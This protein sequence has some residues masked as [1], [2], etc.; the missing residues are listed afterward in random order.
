MCNGSSMLRRFRFLILSLLL[1]VLLGGCRGISK[2]PVAM[3]LS[4]N[5]EV[6]NDAILRF[7]DSPHFPQL[8]EIC[9][10][11]V[12][13]SRHEIRYDCTRVFDLRPEPKAVPYLIQALKD[14]HW[15]VR[16]GAVRALATSGDDRA[17]E[18][19]LELLKDDE[20][21]I[22]QYAAQAFQ[23]FKHPGAVSP[24]I[25]LLRYDRPPTNNGVRDDTNADVAK[26]LGNQGDKKALGHLAR[27]LEYPQERIARAAAEALGKVTGKDFMELVPLE[28][29]MD[30]IRMGSPT[31]AREW[32]RLHPEYR[33]RNNPEF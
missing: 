33:E 10:L 25:A 14:E 2:D 8:D 12:E 19:L 27:L 21:E 22:R 6:R 1:F 9:R 7:R 3:L 26:A 20:P 4:H 24:L 15:L 17:T 23:T 11:L 28:R 29:G 31:K 13:S 32:L 5:H 30:G 18:P 16:R